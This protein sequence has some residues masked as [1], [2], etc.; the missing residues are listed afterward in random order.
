M[1]QSGRLLE[2]VIMVEHT[3]AEM[4][5]VSINRW[6]T[7]TA[8]IGVV[9]GLAFLIIEIRHASNVAE[10]EAYITRVN[11]ID[12]A[13]VDF[14]LS[15]DL[16][17]IYVTA[18]TK[19]VEALAHDELMRARSF[20]NAKRFRIQGQYYLFERGL[21]TDEE[22]LNGILSEALRSE[23]L[24]SA[25]GIGI[26]DIELQEALESYKVDRARSN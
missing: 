21:L 9:V 16:A 19:G 13:Q 8:N 22:S 10:A 7:L 18:R 20:E 23:E 4:K 24:W 5:N 17:G 3:D 25:L 2:D 1:T 12:E 6:L 11:R 15:E 14:A 26:S